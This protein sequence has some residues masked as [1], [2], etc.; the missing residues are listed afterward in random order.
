MNLFDTLSLLIYRRGKYTLEG[1]VEKMYNEELKNAVIK[2]TNGDAEAFSDIY[3][4]TKDGFYNLIYSIT[5]NVELAEDILQD[6]YV[7]IS[8]SIFQL[9]APEAFELE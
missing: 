1:M 2:Y 9:E 4:L 7:K 3:N 6:A 8:T 5:E